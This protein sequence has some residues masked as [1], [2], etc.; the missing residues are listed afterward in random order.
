MPYRLV[1]LNFYCICMTQ[2]FPLLSGFWLL[3]DYNGETLCKVLWYFNIWFN[4][5]KLKY[6]VAF[7]FE[8]AV[9]CGMF[10]II[11]LLTQSYCLWTKMSKA[12]LNSPAILPASA[13]YSFWDAVPNTA[14]EYKYVLNVIYLLSLCVSGIIRRRQVYRPDCWPSCLWCTKQTATWFWDARSNCKI[15]NIL[16]TE[17][18][19]CLGSRNGT[20]QQ[21]SVNHQVQSPECAH[22]S[23]GLYCIYVGIIPF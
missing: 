1:N 12:A 17:Y 3:T 7:Q 5:I 22:S 10:I 19:Y 13:C 16:Q 6:A 23:K 21:T 15:S 4:C 14:L 2:I 18:E 11:V 8:C 9:N 20:L